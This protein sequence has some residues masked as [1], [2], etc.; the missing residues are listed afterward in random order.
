MLGGL[1]FISIL[2]ALSLLYAA[3]GSGTI[4]SRLSLKGAG[5]SISGVAEEQGINGVPALT[6]PAD[7]DHRLV[8]FGDAWSAIGS[9]LAAKGR[10]WP[11]WV[12]SMW[13]CRLESYAQ[14]EHVCESSVCG[15]V[16][17]E[18]ELHT[19]ASDAARS[20]EPLPDLRSQLDQW[21]A[22]ELNAS[23][24]GGD[25]RVQSNNTIFAFSFLIWDIWKFNGI[26]TGKTRKSIM[27]SLN[28][29]FQQ[30][31]RL[32]KYTESDDLRILLMMSID[33]TFLPAFDPSQKQKDMIS[34]V[35]DWNE[36]LKEKANDW[37][38]GSVY[39]FNTN[40]FLNDQIRSRQFYLAGMLDGQGL[41]NQNPWDDVE[42]PCVQSK[43]TWL[44]FLGSKDQRCANPERFLFWDGL[45]LGPTANKMMAT[46]IFHD[47]EK[48]WA[49]DT[50]S[51]A[52][53]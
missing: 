8:V 11:E 30:L 16:I 7:V 41:G 9:R 39:V 43:S 18:T 38:S 6:I 45:H 1:A 26:S 21:L 44:P 14:K 42:N 33:P 35:T 53:A 51:T 31:D 23:Q 36:K 46:E 50:N 32:A 29:L 25:L 3:G 2:I 49:K 48:L 24:A 34:I 10:A 47:I 4:G 22:A 17:D 15:A 40:E 19:I 52:S 13:P 27:R 37:K 20:L 5:T 12:C 28:T